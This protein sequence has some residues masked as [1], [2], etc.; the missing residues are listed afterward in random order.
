[1]TQVETGVL[2][3]AWTSQRAPVAMITLRH[4]S[5]PGDKTDF[6]EKDIDN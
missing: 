1:M 2:P 5:Y 3:V 4:E 6:V